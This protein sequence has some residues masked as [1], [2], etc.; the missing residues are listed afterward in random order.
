MKSNNQNS[1]E[2]PEKPG[3]PEITPPPKI[4]PV[5]PQEAPIIEPDKPGTIPPEINP[6]KSDPEKSPT[7]RF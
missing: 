6:E 4:V 2:N 7:C 1:K 5:K 3:V